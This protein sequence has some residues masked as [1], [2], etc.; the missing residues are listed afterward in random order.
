MTN[1]ALTQFT[2]SIPEYYDKGLGP[3]IFAPF[4]EDMAQ[5]VSA[6]SPRHVLEIAA[7]TGILSERLRAALP[8]TAAL[9]VSDLNP[10]MLEIAKAKLAGASGVVFQQADACAMP[11]SNAAFDCAV[12][13]FGV[14]FFPDKDLSFREV[15]RVLR[16]G[17]A[18]LFNVWDDFAFNAF[19][20]IA[21]ETIA[22]FFTSDPPGFYKVPF[23]YAR[24]DPIK[25]L[26]EAAGY[27]RLSFETVR[28]EQRIS[29]VRA[30]A[31]GL[32]LGSP[33]VEEI[34]ARGTAEPQAIIE[35]LNAAFENEF[36]ARS[37]RMELQAIVVSAR[38]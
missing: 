7:G 31:Q 9:L 2:G 34:R 14:M 12:C 13:Q 19:A 38:V 8:A 37:G 33:I 16:P 5:R 21:S 36:G 4:A 27:R 17:G 6:L 28:L 23:G 24:L 32:V 30:F 11:F 35:K 29:D 22:S 18:Y 1:A 15:R 26:L 3:H 10:P 25:A 20:R